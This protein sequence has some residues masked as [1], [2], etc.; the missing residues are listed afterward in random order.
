M[1]GLRGLKFQ[2]EHTRLIGLRMV[3]TMLLDFIP[4]FTKLWKM[5]RKP[6]RIPQHQISRDTLENPEDQSSLFNG[7]HGLVPMFRLS[8]VLQSDDSLRLV[9]TIHLL[10]LRHHFLL[11]LDLL[12]FID[13]RTRHLEL[14]LV[15]L[16]LGDFT[17]NLA[18]LGTLELD[19]AVMAFA[20]RR[21]LNDTVG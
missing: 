16:I 10:R 9:G 5:R 14:H 6:G 8:V 18:R 11:K 1:E 12:A 2:L 19:Q 13:T 3:L 7:S 20:I 17:T 15:N 21:S 4:E